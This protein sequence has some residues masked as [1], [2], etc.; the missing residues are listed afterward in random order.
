MLLVGVG[1]A[2]TGLFLPDA[3]VPV[4]GADRR[5]RTDSLGRARLAGLAGGTYTVEVRRLGYAPLSA[6]VRL[7]G[8]D[9]LEVVLMVRSSAQQLPAVTVRDTVASP[10]LR[11]FEE[12]RKRALGGRFVTRAEIEQLRDYDLGSLLIAKIPGLRMVGGK[13]FFRRG[14]GLGCQ[15]TAYWNGVMLAEGD[16]GA[17][18]QA[19]GVGELGGFEFYTSGFIPVQYQMAGSMG[20]SFGA[21][22]RGGGPSCGVLLLWSRP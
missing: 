20:V 3:D 16:I 14:A 5:A 13:A 21:K 11:E 12:R 18:M 15:P 7:S 6:P 1:D 9:S 4:L 17:V 2:E 22:S 19:G 10:F 8:R